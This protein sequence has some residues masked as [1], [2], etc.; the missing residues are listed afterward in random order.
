MCSFFQFIAGCIDVH[1]TVI[2]Y[3]WFL[4][5]PSLTSFDHRVF[6]IVVHIDLLCKIIIMIRVCFLV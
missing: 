3:N 6:G 5:L 2:T 1:M 4:S